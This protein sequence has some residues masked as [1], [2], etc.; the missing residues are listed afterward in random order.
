MSLLQFK[1]RAL[2]YYFHCKDAVKAQALLYKSSPEKLAKTP[3]TPEDI[4]SLVRIWRKFG[5][6]TPD[7][8]PETIPGN[9][10]SNVTQKLDPRNYF[11]GFSEDEKMGIDRFL[12][13]RYV[14]FLEKHS[15]NRSCCIFLSRLLRKL[16]SDNCSLKENLI[17]TQSENICDAQSEARK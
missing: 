4:L 12:L 1:V 11:E 14:T 13:E 3:V 17:C 7:C 16:H 10:I 15:E 5:T 6:L 8:F 9:N 2:A